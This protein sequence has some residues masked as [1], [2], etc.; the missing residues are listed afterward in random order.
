ML[1]HVVVAGR[2]SELPVVKETVNGTKYATLVLEITRPFKNSNDIYE[3]D[4]VA[5]TLWKG[6]AETALNVCKLRDMVGVKARIQTY[7]VT[8]ENQTYLNYEFVAEQVSFMSVND[9]K[10]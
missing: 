5:I 2:V 9:G 8:K 4:K 3:S 1:N 6:I 10:N 7:S